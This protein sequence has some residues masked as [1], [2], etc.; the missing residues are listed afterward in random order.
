MPEELK[1]RDLLAIVTGLAVLSVRLQ[2]RSCVDHVHRGKSGSH[3]ILP[4]KR[5]VWRILVSTYPENA[6]LR[7]WL[8]WNR[9]E[10]TAKILLQLGCIL[11][12]LALGVK[13]ARLSLDGVSVFVEAR[14]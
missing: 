7:L 5:C 3:A 1:R 13:H 12:L 10:H 2:C 6:A 11:L 4:I 8:A 14:S 9:R